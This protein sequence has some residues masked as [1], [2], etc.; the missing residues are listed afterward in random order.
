MKDR[1]SIME[2]SGDTLIRA[3][4]CFIIDL[5]DGGNFATKI[6]DYD[7]D[8][9]FRM[10]YLSNYN[11]VVHQ[12]SWFGGGEG[13]INIWSLHDIIK[14][15]EYDDLK[16]DPDFSFQVTGDDCDNSYAIVSDTGIMTRN[17]LTGK[18]DN[19]FDFLNLENCHC[20]NE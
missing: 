18:I 2:Y 15:E 6:F 4:T 13:Y 8:D 20:C 16:E 1:T 19:F 5:A 3:V 7:F 14:S 17:V 10:C 9:D 12:G 11:F